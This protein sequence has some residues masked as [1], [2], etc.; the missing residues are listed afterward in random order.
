VAT[1]LVLPLRCKCG[2]EI[3]VNARRASPGTILKCSR[4]GTT[5]KLVGDGARKAQ[6]AVDDL[7]RSLGKLGR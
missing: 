2:K 7:V 4:C 3:R 1:D 5:I 6:R